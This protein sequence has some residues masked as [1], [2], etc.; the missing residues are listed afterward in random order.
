MV[1]LVQVATCNL[2]QWAL[3]FDLNL[4]NVESSI[5][6][7]KAN[8]AR[9]RTGPELELT[10]YGCEDHFL[11]TDTERHAWESVLAL[12][13]SDL[14]D[15]MLVDVGLPVLHRGVRYN[16]RL[17]MCNRRVLLLRPKLCLA[18]DGNYRETRWFT[19]WTPRGGIGDAALEAYPLP[20]AIRA[21]TGQQSVPIGHAIL[22]CEDGATLA[23]ETCEE[24]FAP[25]APHVALSLLGCDIIANGSGSHH[26]LR[27]L[28]VRL[29]LIRNAASKAGGV[30]LYANQQGCDGGRVY[31][32][33]CASVFVNGDMVAQGAQFSVQDVEVIVATVDLDEVRSFR[34]AIAS[35]SVQAAVETPLP[36]VRVPNF[37]LVAAAAAGGV[38]ESKEHLVS[39]GAYSPF[40]LP[41]AP[42]FPRLHIPEEEIAFGPACWL[43]D[44]LRRSGAR[45]YFLPL[46]GGADSA[47]TAAIVGIMCRLV[48]DAIGKG[49][50]RVLA[51]ARRVA[52]LPLDDPYVPADPRELCARILHTCYM[53]TSNS[54]TDTRDRAARLADELGCYHLTVAI[55]PIVSAILSVFTA[56]TGRTP[57]Y[58]VHGGGNNENLALQNIQARMRMVLSYL[59][60]QLLPWVRAGTAATGNAGQVM[61][62]AGFLLVLGSANVDEALRGY[63]TKY[64]CSSADINPIG[65]IAKGD[66]ARFL[67]WASTRF[68]YPTLGTITRAPPTAE[69][70]PITESYV[71]SDE[72]DMGM[73]YEEL[74]VYGRL[75]KVY[76]CGPVEM[77]QRLVA[78]WGKPREAEPIEGE[79]AAA[80]AATKGDTHAGGSAVPAAASPS[81]AASPVPFGTLVARPA[82]TPTEVMTKVRRFFYFY[83]VNRHKLTTLTPS[84][85]AESYS[86]EDNRFDLRPFLYNTAWSRQ[87]AV[88]QRLAEQDEK[89]F[90]ARQAA[91][92]SV[93]AAGA[94]GMRSRTG[95]L[96]MPLLSSAATRV[97]PLG[98]PTHTSALPPTELRKV[99]GGQGDGGLAQKGASQL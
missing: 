94:S 86:P 24:L 51:D 8:G 39:G 40:L 22:Q 11:E 16:C 54:S 66:L 58:K 97:Q 19:E 26:A 69:L 6:Q 73:S 71:Q 43:W 93:G 17:F 10:G 79:P 2:N 63:M 52:G 36:V 62:G 70:E 81:G 68:P 30:Y 82:L 44:Y 89:A 85:H 75:R 13:Q 84:Y 31:Y 76:R 77:Y 21:F 18:N 87:F 98:H 55:D 48:V 33:G 23:S 7:A 37:R 27:K 41:S 25:R 38:S 80:A 78:L 95:S 5:R 4:A 56:L 12:L 83:S 74:G 9:F 88:L 29:A 47:A 32:D 15:D 90:Q 65:G 14:T 49:D 61:S 20:H 59:L 45:G 34:A 57:R 72:A 50:R 92:G 42:M 35:R 3:D 91:G 64:D 60:A 96:Q 53:G 46:S 28:D 67:R 99:D 1:Q